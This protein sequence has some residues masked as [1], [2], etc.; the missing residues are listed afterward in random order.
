MR[1]WENFL[2]VALLVLAALL[3]FGGLSH[4]LHE[5]R[6]YHPDTAKQ[7][8][9]VELYYGG[10]YF[11]HVG[12][13]DYD[14]YPL[15]HARIAE[16]I[17]RVIEPVRSG[18]CDLL[19]IPTRAGA[20]VT[21]FP[22]YWLMLT[23]NA[24]LSTL[25]V[26][27][28]FR[29]GRENF[30]PLAGWVAAALMA[31]SPA[32]ITS[33][34]MAAGDVTTGFF[35]A[36]SLFWTFRVF[37]LGR[38]RDY[39]L[40]AVFATFA[41]AAK[42]YAA[43][44]FFALA[45]AYITR[46]GI[47]RPAAWFSPDALRRIGVAAI[48]A[49]I[50]LL[51]AIPALLTDFRAE[52]A[53]VWVAL[54]HS[55][56][57]YPASLIGAGQWKR[58]CFSMR[59]NLPDLIRTIS[60]LTLAAVAL[61]FAG[62]LRRD[63][64]FWILLI[65]PVLY[66]FLAVGSRGLVNPIYHIDITPP[67]FLPVAF[68]GSWVFEITGRV[69]AL[70]RVLYCA[71]TA[72]A[73]GLFAA[74][75]AREVFF[76]WHMD[77]RRVCDTWVNANVPHIFLSHTGR[78]TLRWDAEDHPDVNVR[79]MVFISSALDPVRVPDYAIPLKQFALEE[80]PLTQFRNIAEKV[81]VVC[82]A[83][84]RAGF[85]LPVSQRWPSQAENAFIMD[86]GAEFVRSEK[87]FILNHGEGLV[88]W[89][90]E[91][92]PLAEVW[93]A[94]KTSATSSAVRIQFEG[95]HKKFHFDQDTAAVLHIE[96]PRPEFP[97]GDGRFFYR[98]EIDAPTA[99]M[100]IMLAT[101]LLDAGRLFA[102]LGRDADAAP[103]LAKGATAANDPA[104]AAQAII[105]A[106][107]AGIALPRDDSARLEKL[108]AKVL[109]ATNAY[110]VFAVFGIHPDYLDAL[111]FLGVGTAQM[112]ANG[113]RSA[114]LPFADETGESRELI[115]TTNARA[116][117]DGNFY[118]V[119]TG[120]LMLD[121]GPYQAKLLARAPSGASHGQTLK[122]T[123][124]DEN[125]KAIAERPLEIPPLDARAYTVIPFDL[126]VPAGVA[127][128]IITLRSDEAPDLAVGGIE[129]RPDVVANV[130]ALGKALAPAKP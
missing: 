124:R 99:R 12:N 24:A 41:F 39:A 53:D 105:S 107:R 33:T 65:G 50:A 78:Y 69:R 63:A 123:V 3:R 64:R 116:R 59:V 51:V 129:I 4:D 118:G 128:V 16:C 40:A 122:L 31:I 20:L 13:K 62:R 15:F 79:G 100:K 114:P 52:L 21:D 90:V 34:H 121:P 6:L 7:V 23:M 29:A 49:I 75:A 94:V 60:P 25:I 101:D 28:V 84:L 97:T 126:E 110:A 43:T 120:L 80:T 104:A 18:V 72:S 57:R 87:C 82:P 1:R 19:G 27:I 55:T 115:V 42:Y 130:I 89:I 9:A 38:Y 103:L 113:F 93:I 88:R 35:A 117:P 86:N 47:T 125:G 32:D 17:L 22:V 92:K 127:G 106:S 48:A 85:S 14:G 66:V 61:S 54:I 95:Q 36:L 76:A 37:R 46:A 30:G 81:S 119:W 8:R 2:L 45:L 68:F 108:A 70:S 44:A 11:W 73:L 77:T 83:L 26:L 98:L 58:Y 5:G 91:S 10:H 102:R 71:A 109:T 56:Q 96:K 67:L 112:G 74:D 111:P